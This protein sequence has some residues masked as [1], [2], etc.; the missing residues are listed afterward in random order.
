MEKADQPI[1]I[2]S[3]RWLLELQL[4]RHGSLDFDPSLTS[5]LHGVGSMKHFRAKFTDRKFNSHVCTCCFVAFLES[6]KLVSKFFR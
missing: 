6:N 5:K 1:L 2:N 4:V 3:E